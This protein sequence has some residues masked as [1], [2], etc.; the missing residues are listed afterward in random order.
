VAYTTTYAFFSAILQLSEQLPVM[1][2]TLP[3][4]EKV[5]FQ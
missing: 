1:L 4:L 3:Q 5:F 2:F